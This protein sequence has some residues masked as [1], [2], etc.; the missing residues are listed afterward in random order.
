MSVEFPLWKGWTI[1]AVEERAGENVTF[2]IHVSAAR[3]FKTRTAAR[4]K[5]LLR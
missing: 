4:E 3:A 1:V 2:V 5:M